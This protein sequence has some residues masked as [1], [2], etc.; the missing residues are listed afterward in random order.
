MV[1]QSPYIINAYLNYKHLKKGMDATL[2]YN[3]QG[4]RLSVVGV[5]RNP[6]VYEQSFHSLNVKVSKSFGK[7]DNW[8]ASFSA[9]NVLGAQR[10]LD[11][12]SY[13]AKNQVFSLLKPMRSF[14]LG[15]SYSL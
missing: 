13:G 7:K 3:V 6:D 15:F 9:R 14:S 11:N 8:R 5:A 10:L 2:T 1:G 12:V 4:P